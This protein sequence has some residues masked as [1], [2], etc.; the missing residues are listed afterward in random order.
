MWITHD[1]S[2]ISGLADEVC[3][4][5]AGRIVE[6]GSVDDIL[7]RPMHPYTRGLLDPVPSRNTPGRPLAQIR[8]MTPS[9]LAL[10]EGCAFRERCAR[11]RDECRVAPPMRTAAPGRSLRCVNP[12]S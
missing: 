5:Y 10:G 7:D 6:S 2:V 12:L 4:M 1:L 9:L 8:G 3:V 11:T